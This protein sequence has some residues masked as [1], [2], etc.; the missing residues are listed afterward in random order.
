MLLV[1]RLKLNKADTV[2]LKYLLNVLKSVKCM[3]RS[4]GPKV[5]LLDADMSREGWESSGLILHQL[6]GT[7]CALG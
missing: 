2:H 3:A 1:R 5:L 4:S 6:L 7:V